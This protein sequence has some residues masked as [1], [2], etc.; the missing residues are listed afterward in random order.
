MWENYFLLKN[1]GSFY[2]TKGIIHCER[3]QESLIRSVTILN[4]GISVETQPYGRQRT[5]WLRRCKTMTGAW[6]GK[7]SKSITL[8]ERAPILCEMN[9]FPCNSWTWEGSKCA[10]FLTNQYV[11]R[12]DDLSIQPVKSACKTA[13]RSEFIAQSSREANIVF[14]GTNKIPRDHWEKISTLNRRR[15]LTKSLCHNEIHF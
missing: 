1:E 13:L 12:P 3:Q 6:Q 4:N 2:G 5:R 8:M 14:V 7:T 15:N 9:V 11:R 10:F